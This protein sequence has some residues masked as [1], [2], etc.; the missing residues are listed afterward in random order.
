MTGQVL[1][2][3]TASILILLLPLALA[4][5]ILYS[6]WPAL[7]ALVILALAWNLWQTYHW[8]QWSAQVNPFFNEL[9]TENQGCVTAIDLSLKANLTLDAAQ[10]F[11]EN[12]ANEYGA[13]RK[14]YGNKG[15]VYYFLTASALGRIFD[16]SEPPAQGIG[17]A[18]T[19]GE[20]A[21]LA[22]FPTVNPIGN[23]ALIQ[24]E[25]AKRLDVH[26]GTLTKRK[27]DPTFAEWSRNKDPEGIAWQYSAKQKLFLPLVGTNNDPASSPT[28]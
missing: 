14:V 10:R 4:V 28:G 6:A 18:L 27:G 11:L 3:N 7:L 5:V 20:L 15:I 22:T 9:L 1:D 2:K 13:Q 23:K 17:E 21:Q 19:S 12:K 25:L 8:K 16:A 26:S 24:A